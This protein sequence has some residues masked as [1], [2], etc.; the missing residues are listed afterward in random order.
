MRTNHLTL[1]TIDVVEAREK[2][3]E[4]TRHAGMENVIGSMEPHAT[5]LVRLFIVPRI[6]R[7]K[8][9]AGTGLQNTVLVAPFR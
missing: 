1:M 8:N 3:I 4:K 6:V 2:M 9:T 5:Y 7:Y